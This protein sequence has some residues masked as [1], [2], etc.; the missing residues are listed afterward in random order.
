MDEGGVRQGYMQRIS[1]RFPAQTGEGVKF[2]S[3]FLANTDQ[4]S[5]GVNTY[6]VFSIWL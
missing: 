4:D 1:E 3:T 2:P 6:C 5:C